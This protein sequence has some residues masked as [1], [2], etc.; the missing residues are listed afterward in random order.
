MRGSTDSATCFGRWYAALPIAC[1]FAAWRTK[2]KDIARSDSFVPTL[3]QNP[4]S[5]SRRPFSRR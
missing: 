3:R 5:S 1:A 4:D 2:K